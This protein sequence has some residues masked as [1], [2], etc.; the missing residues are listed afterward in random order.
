MLLELLRK[1]H[2]EP[3]K[4]IGGGIYAFQIRDHP[5][6]KSKCFFL[7]REDGSTDDFSFR[8]CVDHILPL[9]EEMRGSKPDVKKTLG[10]GKS[11][12]RKGGSSHGKGGKSKYRY[13]F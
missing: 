3:D 12:G 10:G 13:D 9:P 4:K 5:I 1:G 8:K 11:R 2:Q 6:W 7:I